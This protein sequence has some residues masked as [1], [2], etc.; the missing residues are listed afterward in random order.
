MARTR[1]Y[2]KYAKEAVKLLGSQI[3]LARKERRWTELELAERAGIGRATLQ[4]IERGDL[5]CSIGLTFELA[6][7]LGL[8]LFDADSDALKMHLVQTE[9]RIALLP[10]HI[11]PGRKAVDD[12]F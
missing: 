2:S 12:D 4:R 3:R 6:A 7:L 5:A 8:R 11:R 9:N 10:K 1:A